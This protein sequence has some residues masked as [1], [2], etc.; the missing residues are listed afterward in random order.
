VSRSVV[1]AFTPAQWATAWAT[2]P[3]LGPFVPLLE[4]LTGEQGW[5]DVS[6]YC[7]LLGTD[8]DFACPTTRLPAGLDASDVDDSYIGRCVRGAVPTRAQNLHDLMNALT[9]AAFPRAKL[10]LCRRQVDVARARGPRTNRLRT[11]AQ[12]R[13]AMLDEGGVLALPGGDERVF[14][15]GLLEDLILGRSSR[16]LP[17]AV[18]DVDDDTVATAITALP[19]PATA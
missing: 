13:L 18:D 19:L 14:G 2:R 3:D 4:R 7:A 16:G 5:P 9:W 10:A 17:L 6:R 8:V 15:H 1:V 12:D 11:R